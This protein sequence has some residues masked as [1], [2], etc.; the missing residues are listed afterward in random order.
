MF[1]QV[2]ADYGLHQLVLEGTRGVN[3]LDL[4]LTNDTLLIS[5]LCVDVPF[6]SSDHN[7]IIVKIYSSLPDVISNNSRTSHEPVLWHDWENAD[8]L[9]FAYFL[10]EIDWLKGYRENDTSNA[11]WLFLKNALSDGTSLFVPTKCS[12]PT[13]GQLIAKS[14]SITQKI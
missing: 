6:G 13:N 14:R 4:V 10:G 7:S 12:R 9:S 11:A 5:D 3:I 1:L 2:C 8:W